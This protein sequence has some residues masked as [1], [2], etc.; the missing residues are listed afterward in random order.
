MPDHLLRVFLLFLLTSASAFGQSDR[1]AGTID[2][3]ARV[4]LKGNSNPRARAEFDRGAVDRSLRMSGVTLNFRIAQA[5][6][7]AL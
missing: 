5:Q 6:Q 1:I 4:I 3:S 2:S 7:T